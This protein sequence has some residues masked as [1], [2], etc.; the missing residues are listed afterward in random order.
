[1]STLDSGLDRQALLRSVDSR[2]PAQP[3][4]KREKYDFS[5]GTAPPASGLGGCHW[6][7][8][9]IASKL[10]PTHG[11]ALLNQKMLYASRPIKSSLPNRLGTGAPKTATLI[12]QNKLDTHQCIAFYYVSFRSDADGVATQL[13]VIHLQHMAADDDSGCRRTSVS[14]IDNSPEI[15]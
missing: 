1:M 14:S 2:Q 6:A 9:S 11:E 12:P 4:R 10:L 13:R 7:A 15:L 5:S 8:I 3:L